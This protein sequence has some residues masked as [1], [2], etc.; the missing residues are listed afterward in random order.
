VRHRRSRACEFF[1]P[2]FEFF[3]VFVILL[4][5]GIGK[6]AGRG[7]TLDLGFESTAPLQELGIGFIPIPVEASDQLFL[8]GAIQ[9]NGF[10]EDGLAR[11]LG[12][13][14]FDHLEPTL[15]L[16]GLRQ[17]TDAA[18]EVDGAQA[19]DLP[20]ECDALLGRLRRDFVGQ[21]QP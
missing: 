1:E 14:V 8:L 17:Q 9:T 21:E 7:L 4:K 6:L 18:L 13:V 3:Q 12:N 5:L 11:H 10:K 19:F 15:M 16:V 2:T 20:P